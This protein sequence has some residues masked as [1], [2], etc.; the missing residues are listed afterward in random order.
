MVCAQWFWR[1]NK[2]GGMMPGYPI[3][4]SRFWFGFPENLSGVDAVYEKPLGEAIVFF[5]GLDLIITWIYL[6]R[7]LKS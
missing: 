6:Y 2:E 7:F 5:K 1:L 4:I 3:Q